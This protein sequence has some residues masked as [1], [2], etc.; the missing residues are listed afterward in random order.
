MIANSYGKT[1]SLH[2]TVVS[3]PKIDFYVLRLSITGATLP[4]NNEA[5]NILPLQMAECLLRAQLDS[6][7]NHITARLN[8]INVS[9]T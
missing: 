1:V 6:V 8:S 2:D 7:A 9:N 5:A 4:D 3:P